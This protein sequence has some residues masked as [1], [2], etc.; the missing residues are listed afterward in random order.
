LEAS[1]KALKVPGPVSAER[2]IAEADNDG[3]GKLTLAEFIARSNGRFAQMDLNHDGVLDP[4]E[5]AKG[6]RNVGAPATGAAAA[7]S[8][9]PSARH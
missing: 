3:D 5:W 9:S 7:P 8:P 2:T 1:F 6:H 4:D